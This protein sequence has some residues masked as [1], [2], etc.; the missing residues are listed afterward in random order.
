MKTYFTA[1][2]SRCLG[3][4]IALM[5]A[6]CVY[7]PGRATLHVTLM[8]YAV[9]CQIDDVPTVSHS[10]PLLVSVRNISHS[11]QDVEYREINRCFSVDLYLNGQPVKRK[12]GGRSI[13]FSALRADIE[14]STIDIGEGGVFS[15]IS[16]GEC[17]RYKL[18]ISSEFDLPGPGRY[19]VVAHYCYEGVRELMYIPGSATFAIGSSIPD[20]VKWHNP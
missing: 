6:G 1:S 8:P 16:M 9:E 13:A 12:A 11:D 7:V 15:T 3:L 17:A 20:P 14:E 5:T 2:V 19:L 10:I 4:A 18:D